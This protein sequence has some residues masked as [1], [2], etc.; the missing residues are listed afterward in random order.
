MCHQH[1]QEEEQDGDGAHQHEVLEHRSE[2]ITLDGEVEIEFRVRCAGDSLPEAE[3]GVVVDQVVAEPGVQ[4]IPSTVNK[5]SIDPRQR[6]RRQVAIGTEIGDRNDT[7]DW[8]WRPDPQPDI[9]TVE[10]VEAIVEVLPKRAAEIPADLFLTILLD[11]PDLV[12]FVRLLNGFRQ[13][14][15]P[16]DVIR[17]LRPVRLPDKTSHFDVIGVEKLK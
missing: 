1:Q 12:C 14:D 17:Y 15:A 5:L 9:L 7:L 13:Y 4:R 11:P 6:V 16:H 2:E 10:G 3:I 8:I